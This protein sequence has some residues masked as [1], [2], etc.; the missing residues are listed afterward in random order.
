MTG[1]PRMYIVNTGDVLDEVDRL[2]DEDIQRCHA[3]L[4]WLRWLGL[5][6]PLLGLFGTVRFLSRIDYSYGFPMFP[7]EC[8]QGPVPVLFCVPLA[9]TA[10]GLLMALAFLP[11]HHVL[12]SKATVLLLKARN[13]IK[14]VFLRTRP[15]REIGRSLS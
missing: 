13:E 8:F 4:G 1:E 12:Q 2:V 6:G 9:L 3:R 14:A 15:F 10:A 11:A 7:S 5:I